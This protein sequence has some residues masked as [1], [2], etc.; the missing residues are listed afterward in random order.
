[1]LSLAQPNQF[2]QIFLAQGICAGIGAGMLYVP[3]VPVPEP[4]P[5]LAIVESPARYTVGVAR[6]SIVP[7][8]RAAADATR[9]GSSTRREN[10]MLVE[11]WMV[12]GATPYLV[13]SPSPLYTLQTEQEGDERSASVRS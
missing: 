6:L 4:P 13:V 12:T 11:F 9:A 3:S 7:D 10:F 8:G 2:Y 5:F 1:M